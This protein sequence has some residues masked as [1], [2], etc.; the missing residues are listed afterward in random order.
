MWLAYALVGLFL[1]FVAFIMVTIEENLTGV[2]VNGVNN[3]I[4]DAVKEK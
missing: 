4:I 3:L 2:I 1:G